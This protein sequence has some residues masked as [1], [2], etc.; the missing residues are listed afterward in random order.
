MIFQFLKGATKWEKYTEYGEERRAITFSLKGLKA[1][2]YFPQ[3]H[4]TILH[5]VIY[6][7]KKQLA[8]C[9]YVNTEKHSFQKSQIFQAVKKTR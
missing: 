9:S 5:K 6:N 2:L 4:K 8:Y 3:T 7:T 1:A